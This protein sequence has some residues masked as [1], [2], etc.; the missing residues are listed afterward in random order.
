MLSSEYYRVI[1]PS[2]KRAGNIRATLAFGKQLVIA[3]HEFEVAEYAAK[4]PNLTIMPIPDKFR[5]NMG[6]VRNFIRDTVDTPWLLMVDDDV[7]E[8]GK[9]EEGHQIPMGLDEIDLLILNGFTMCEELGTVLWGVNLQSDPKF[10]REYSP[11][12]LLSPVLGPFSGHILR[13]EVVNKVRY[14]ERLGLNEDY[15]Y[16]LQ[17]L[18]KYRKILRMNKY[19]YIAGHLRDRGG[20]GAYRMMDEEI[21][22]SKIMVKKWG[23]KVVKYNLKKSTN[24]ELYCPLA[25]I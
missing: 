3:C 15:D 12:S 24:P 13:P 19:Y 10:Y 22:Q 2:Y 5:G 18:L 23:P 4:N 9:H 17:V 16:A 21:K 11:F 6:A 8:I 25:G 1:C 7:D 20:C 14:D